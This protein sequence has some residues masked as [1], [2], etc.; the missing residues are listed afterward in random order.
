MP[1]AISRCNV[2]RFRPQPIQRVLGRARR[3]SRY[4]RAFAGVLGTH[5]E[6]NGLPGRLTRVTLGKCEI[7]AASGALQRLSLALRRPNVTICFGCARLDFLRLE[8]CT[9]FAKPIKRGPFE[10]G[11]HSPASDVG[12]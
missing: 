3:G 10:K 11:V 4:G 12:C 7:G 8:A 5:S 2:D 9:E 1:S 6:E